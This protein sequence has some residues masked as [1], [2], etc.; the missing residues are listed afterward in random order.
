MKT[1]GINDERG[2]FEHTQVA[3]SDMAGGV[4]WNYQYA[5]TMRGIMQLLD[6]LR[7]VEGFENS[8]D[9]GDYVENLSSMLTFRPW[10]RR[11][12]E[13]KARNEVQAAHER[14][15]RGE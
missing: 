9:L 1:D 3:D 11:D 2:Q 10:T 14:I 15:T 13:D 12:L 8:E 7:Q 4:D 6:H 5:L